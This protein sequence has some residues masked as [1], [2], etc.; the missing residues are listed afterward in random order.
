MIFSLPLQNIK[1]SFGLMA[2]ILFFYKYNENV[3]NIFRHD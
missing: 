1:E 3:K 2:E